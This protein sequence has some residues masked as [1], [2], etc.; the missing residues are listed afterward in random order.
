MSRSLRRRQ[1]KKA[2]RNAKRRKSQRDIRSRIIAE[3]QRLPA[4][5]FHPSRQPVSE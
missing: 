2:K 5:L 3:I 1:L 4:A